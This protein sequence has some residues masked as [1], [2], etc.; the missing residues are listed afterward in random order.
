M[1]IGMPV[2]LRG[3]GFSAYG[4]INF[5]CGEE[6]HSCRPDSTLADEHGNFAVAL[7][8][9]DKATWLAGSHRLVAYDVKTNRSVE[10]TVIFEVL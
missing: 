9:G 10:L 3:E 4:R 7:I 1:V 2:Q 5:T 6:N 8:P